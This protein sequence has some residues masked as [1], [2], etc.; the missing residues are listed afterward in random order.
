V[1]NKLLTLNTKG[2]SNGSYFIAITHAKGTRTAT[3]QVA[4]S[5]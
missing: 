1:N 5:L 2:W 3:F 4:R